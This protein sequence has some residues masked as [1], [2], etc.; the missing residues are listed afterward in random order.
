MENYSFLTIAPC[1]FRLEG[2]MF[3]L[4]TGDTFS[5][6]PSMGEKILSP[7]FYYRNFI[8][9]TSKPSKDKLSKEPTDDFELST[10]LDTSI[11]S[12][13]KNST[14]PAQTANV[15]EPVEP[16]SIESIIPEVVKP[17]VVK[18]EVVKPEAVKPEAIKI[19]TKAKTSASKKA[20]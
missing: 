15:I 18:S 6:S 3:T 11:T 8:T 17:E 10:P 4:R 2:E 13:K 7:S 19:E 12:K 14:K 9:L 1:S 16:V 5:V 20:V